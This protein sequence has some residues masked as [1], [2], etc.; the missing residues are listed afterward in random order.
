MFMFNN[1]TDVNIWTEMLYFDCIGEMGIDFTNLL[2]VNKLFE[3][4]AYRFNINI[5]KI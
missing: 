2:S 4:D 1:G 5:F 3:T